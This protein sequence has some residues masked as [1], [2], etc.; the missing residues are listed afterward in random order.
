MDISLDR[1]PLFPPKEAAEKLRKSE[2]TLETWRRTGD[3]PAFLKL[4]RRAV[5]YRLSD[6]ESWLASR[7]RLSTNDT[8]KAA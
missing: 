6:L 8:G 7:R 3:G 5:F 1:D 2:R 4:G